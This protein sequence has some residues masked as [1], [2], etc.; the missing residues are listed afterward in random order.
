MHVV[1]SGNFII[2]L[3]CLEALQASLVHR[4][5]LDLRHRYR[6]LTNLRK[7]RMPVAIRVED[8]LVD[9]LGKL[10]LIC[11]LRIRLHSRR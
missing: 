3:L 5:G 8:G 6:L 7:L 1:Q 10:Q 2:R 9:F 11:P 4:V